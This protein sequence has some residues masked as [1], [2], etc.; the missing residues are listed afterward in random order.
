MK[1]PTIIIEGMI[2]SADILDKIETGEIDGQSPKHFGLEGSQKVKDEI[3]RIW[4]DCK[5]L[6]QVYSRQMNK[7]GNSASGAAET[8]RYWML[9]LL[10]LLGYD[11][12]N[13]KTEII[14]EKTYAISHRAVNLRGFP[15][16]IMGFNDKL[17]EKRQDGGPR[18][19]PHSLVQEYINITEHLYAL[20]TNGLRLRLLR[21]NSRLIKQSYIEFDLQAMMEE[22]HYADFAVMVRLLHATRMPQSIEAGDE[23]LIEKYHQESLDSGSRIR[24]K[25]SEAVEKSIILLGTGFLQ[26]PANEELCREIEVNRLTADQLYQ[27]Q[28]RLIYR[29]LFLLVI[30][31]RQ[32]VFPEKTDQRKREI[33]YRYYSLSRLRYLSESRSLEEGNYSDLWISLRQ[34]F[35]LYEDEAFGAKLGVQPLNGV[36]FGP[37]GL[38]ILESCSLDNTAL[39]ACIAHLS[40]YSDEA[41]RHLIRVNYAGLNVEEFGSVYEGLLEY[42]PKIEQQ[43]GR[44]TFRFVKGTERSSSGTHYT[45]DELVLPL[46]KHSLDHIIQDK[47]SAPLDK[48]P[49]KPYDGRSSGKT[50]PPEDLA[51]IKSEQ[52]AG[53]LSIKVCDAACGSGHILLNAARRIAQA[54]ATVRSGED[55][56]SPEVLRP[57]IRDV[58]SRC[59]YGVDKNPLAVELCKVALWLE[60]HNPGEPLSFLDHRIKCGDAIVGLAHLQEL[61]NG[62]SDEAFKPLPGDDKTICRLLRDRN[63]ADRS[64]SKF[65]KDF[66]K[67]LHRGVNYLASAFVQ[68]D[69]MPD[70]QPKHVSDKSE[71]YI[72]LISGPEYM[73]LK[74]LADIQT[75][76]FFIPKFKA[77]DCITDGLFREYLAGRAMQGQ[78][79]AKA[80]VV[81]VEK[82]FFHWF[83]EFPEVMA[84]GGFDCILGNPPFLGGQKISTF[85]SVNYMKYLH[86]KYD[87]TKATCDLVA[88]FFRRIFEATRLNG[89]N[90]L[91]A[92]NTISQ[93]DTREGGLSQIVKMSGAIIYAVRSIRWP[94]KAA[95]EVALVTLFKGKWDNIFY[96]N[97]Q[98]VKQITDLLDDSDI[99][100]KP[101]VLMQNQDKSFIGSYVLGTGFIIE[102][103][104][105]DELISRNSQNAEVLFRYLN[106]DDINSRPDQSPS[107]W[108]I[109]FH[110]WPLEK[111]RQ[112][113][114]PFRIVEEKVKPERTRLK[115]DGTFVLRRP[116]PQKWW[117]YA[118]KRPALYRTI[119]P[120]ERVLV[121]SLVSKYPLFIYKEAN[122][123]FS[124]RCAVFPV[125]T[126][127]AAILSSTL[128]QDWVYKYTSTLGGSTINYSPSDCFITFPFANLAQKKELEN[129]LCG[130]FEKY[131]SFRSAL[132]MKLK[133]GLTKTYNQFHN[134][135]LPDPALKST[136]PAQ[137][138]KEIQTQLGKE[139][140]NLFMH[141]NQTKDDPYPFSEAIGEII[142]LRRIHIQLDLAV[143]SA[144]GWDKSGP[145]GPAIDLR[146]DF[147]EVD[148]LPEN[149]RIRF[150]IHP[151]ARR[152]ILKRLLLLN[153]RIHEEEV[154]AGLC[155]N[156]SPKNENVMENQISLD[157]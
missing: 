79:V 76:Q 88:F 118:E 129:N 97:H 128:H 23:S 15:I 77:G 49:K 151:D 40:R 81:A 114:E 12:Q 64:E 1:F 113:I 52:E 25:L 140:Y 42:A 31:E 18:L 50:K 27:L 90:S 17:G 115:P 102:K 48:A 80:M 69:T 43:N 112:Y 72:R 122:I 155:K 119:A 94:G 6:W 62:I 20:V 127:E 67:D 34:T 56:P 116:M 91:I 87:G 109:N 108:V 78:A 29:L 32:L 46:I 157:V 145:D 100:D 66:R 144:Y 3:A 70:H 110:D 47:L 73:R 45:P 36:L 131:Y 132:T 61:Q 96:L 84:N 120:L 30:E 71:A 142:E 150:T 16:H 24:E 86:V 37:G 39:L 2:I 147:Y 82:R 105:V 54:L 104:K 10:G 5:D 138:S 143:L 8:R 21:D 58:I 107:R 19:S 4:A 93:G 152:E 65:M 83:L 141:L 53:L 103:D 7:I 126:I 154:K 41:S 123:V 111:A 14:N 121:N 22:N 11:T 74:T 139:T 35:R 68:L 75:A 38:G 99:F 130:A 136:W 124:H 117:I 95:L 98:K 156:E 55:Q 146:H 26:H 28:L 125:N 153:H 148:Y 44:W 149:D 9:P 133:L 13:F 51:S 60:A 89:F 134:A 63:K 57:A 137:Y 101:F 92:T 85:L 59:I 33:Y 135:Q 106:G